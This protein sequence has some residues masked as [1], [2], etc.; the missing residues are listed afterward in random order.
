MSDSIL[1]TLIN[2]VTK[3]EIQTFDMRA[4]PHKDDFLNY[5]IDNDTLLKLHI[6]HVQWNV[7]HALG[8]PSSIQQDV[9]LYV[10]GVDEDTIEYIQKQEDEED[11]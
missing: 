6:T 1:V 7:S 4:I 5:W 2:D 8:N 11:E 9:T 10:L 3:R